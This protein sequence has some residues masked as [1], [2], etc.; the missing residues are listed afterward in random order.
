MPAPDD[1]TPRFTRQVE[2][3]T[4]GHCGRSVRGNGYTNHCPGCLWSR[5]VDVNPGDRAAACGGLM[6]PVAV[7]ST[8]HRYTI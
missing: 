6:E 1:A 3:F 5:H 4:C 8:R 7:A 2:D